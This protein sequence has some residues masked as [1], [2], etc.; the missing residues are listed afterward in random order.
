VL[1][2]SLERLFEKCVKPC[3]ARVGGRFI[4]FVILQNMARQNEKKI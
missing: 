1:G 3:A 2:G 4:E